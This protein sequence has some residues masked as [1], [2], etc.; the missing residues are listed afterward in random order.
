VVENSGSFYW[1]RCLHRVRLYWQ[2]EATKHSCWI[3]RSVSVCQYS[4]QYLIVYAAKFK[5][6]S[7]LK[8]WNHSNSGSCFLKGVL[9]K[10]NFLFFTTSCQMSNI[11]R[12]YGQTA[13]RI[14]SVHAEK[15]C[16][17]TFKIQAEDSSETPLSIYQLTRH[18][19]P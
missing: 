13:V 7:I 1:W 3:R 14:F 8:A 19:S 10:I 6:N 5:C 12:C 17:W 18:H 4:A 15:K 16:E 2:S 9:L 11:F